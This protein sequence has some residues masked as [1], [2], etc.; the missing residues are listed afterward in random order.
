MIDDE[1][2]EHDRAQGETHKYAV[3]E[4]FFFRGKT[5]VVALHVFGAEG[6]E[7]CIRASLRGSPGGREP[8]IVSPCVHLNNS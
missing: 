2:R 3:I 1:G 6:I 4:F 8:G 5:P 7:R